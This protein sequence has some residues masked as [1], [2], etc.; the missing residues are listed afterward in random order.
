M[1]VVDVDETTSSYE[2]IHTYPES[3]SAVVTKT[4]LF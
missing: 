3:G 2:T 4:E 1:T